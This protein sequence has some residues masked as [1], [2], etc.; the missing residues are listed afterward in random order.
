MIV[1]VIVIVK[2]PITQNTTGESLAFQ[3][4]AVASQVISLASQAGL[5][6]YR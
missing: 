2:L 5:E 1:I 6:H 3:M 4:V